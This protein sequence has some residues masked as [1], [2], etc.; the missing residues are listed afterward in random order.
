M[1]LWCSNIHIFGQL[2]V[3]SFGVRYNHSI[4]LI[5]YVVNK[6]IGGQTQILLGVDF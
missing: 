2:G 5:L 1:S 6:Y 4:Q 3:F